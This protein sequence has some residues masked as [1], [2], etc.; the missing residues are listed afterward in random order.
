LRPLSTR[1]FA[2]SSRPPARDRRLRW[3]PDSRPARHLIL[4]CT[5]LGIRELSAGHA[6]DELER[7]T[8]GSH[9]NV[10]ISKIRRR[11]GAVS[12]Q[13]LA[14]EPLL[15][16]HLDGRPAR[17]RSCGTT[18]RKGRS[19]GHAR[20]ELERI[21]SD[22]HVNVGSSRIRQRARAAALPTHHRRR[23]AS[24]NLQQDRAFGSANL[25][26]P[27]LAGAAIRLS[28]ARRRGPRRQPPPVAAFRRPAR[29]S[30]RAKGGSRHCSRSSSSLRAPC[31]RGPRRLAPPGRARRP[32][33]RASRR[34]SRIAQRRAILQRLLHPSGWAVPPQP[35]FR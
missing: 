1:W 16:L 25:R 12:R 15:L 14:P 18:K 23:A 24:R 5:H 2:R 13:H 22:S 10:D 4:D 9:V 17:C 31:A 30:R 26:G 11:A 35:K 7:I 28:S 29:T 19:A 21:T 6:Q 27:R 32:S 3:R 20:D 8:S 34:P 33:G